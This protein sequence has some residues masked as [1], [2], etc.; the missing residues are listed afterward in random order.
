MELHCPYCG[1]SVHYDRSL[2]GQSTLC[3]YCEKV[4]KMPPVADLPDELQDQLRQE[5]AKLAERAKQKYLRKQERFLKELDREEQEKRRQEELQKQRE[6]EEKI[7]AVR[8]PVLEE[9]AVGDRYPALRKLTRLSKAA[10]WLTLVVY[11]VCL[12]IGMQ[13]AADY[14]MLSGP[15]NVLA[16]LLAA[17]AIFTALVLWA[18]AEMIRLVLDV[19]DDVRMTRLLIKRQTYADREPDDEEPEAAD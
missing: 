6:V 13:Y 4:L 15:I 3:S 9:L 11:G 10:A 8:K 19:A 14:P 12:V 17:A 5:E 1:E 16:V 2:A 18:G 7:E